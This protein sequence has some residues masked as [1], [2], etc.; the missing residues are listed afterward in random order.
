M[1]SKKEYLHWEKLRHKTPPKNLTHEEWWRGIKFK[2]LA[3]LRA[4]ELKDL[5]GNSFKYSIPE[6]IQE[7]LHKIDLGAGGTIAM[8]EPIINQHTKD[9][10]LLRSL[11]EEAITSSQLD[12]AATTR[13]VAKQML[14]SGRNPRDNGEQMILNNFKTMQRIRS[15]KDQPLTPS[16]IFSVHKMVTEKNR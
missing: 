5:K 4:I 14:K 9:K 3:K 8:P 13:E 12:G 11:I 1:P 16:L 2:R 15:L 6:F 10:Y 7:T